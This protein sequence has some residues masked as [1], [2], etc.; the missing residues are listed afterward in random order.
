M[1]S[2]TSA[3]V[4]SG[5]NVKPP[6]ICQLLYRVHRCECVLTNATPTVCVMGPDEVDVAF[7]AADEE[8]AALAEEVIALPSTLDVSCAQTSAAAPRT[9]SDRSIAISTNVS[10]VVAEIR[11]T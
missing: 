9:S 8:A 5:A 2:P 11:S 4:T 3:R 10:G 1:V 7:V 6:W